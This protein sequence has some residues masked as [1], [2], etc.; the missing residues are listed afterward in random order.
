[1]S[2]KIYF[3]QKTV[4]LMCKKGNIKMIVSFV[5]SSMLSWKTL[6]DQKVPTN[7]WCATQVSK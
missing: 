5:V 1:M 7:K 6:K 3:A 4:T 2:S